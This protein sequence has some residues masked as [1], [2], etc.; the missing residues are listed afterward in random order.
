MKNKV[1]SRDEPS[2]DMTKKAIEDNARDE[3]DKDT[4]LKELAKSKQ[5]Y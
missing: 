5:Q 1:K 3:E 4:I 2:E